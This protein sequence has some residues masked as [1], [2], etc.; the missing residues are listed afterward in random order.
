[1]SLLIL[2]HLDRESL[3]ISVHQHCN[4]FVHHFVHPVVLLLHSSVMLY[5]FL[6]SSLDTTHIALE[7]RSLIYFYVQSHYLYLILCLDCH[8]S[9]MTPEQTYQTLPQ[10]LPNNALDGVVEKKTSFFGKIKKVDQKREVF[11]DVL[12]LLKAAFQD[13]YLCNADS[14]CAA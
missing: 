4:H 6:R 13:S 8:L 5:S 1:M 9:H 3:Q 12:N 14:C 7:L 10:H 2:N 11:A